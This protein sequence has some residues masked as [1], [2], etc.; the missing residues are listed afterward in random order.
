MQGNV[1]TTWVRGSVYA[2]LMGLALAWSAACSP[3]DFEEPWEVQKLRVLAVVAEPPELGPGE[4]TEIRAFSASPREDATFSWRWEVCLLTGGP[5]TS[6]AC[7]PTGDA[8][9]DGW[10]ASLGEGA[11]GDLFTLENPLPAEVLD[12]FCDELRA[13]RAELCTLGLP[14]TLRA[15]VT[16]EATGET[17]ITT[18]RMVLLRSDVAEREDRNVNPSLRELTFGEIDLEHNVVVE[19]PLPERGEWIDLEL[20]I[21][22]D[23]AQMYADPDSGEERMEELRVSWFVSGG[24]LERGQTF[25]RASV[26]DG[27]AELKA[28]RWRSHGDRLM[29]EGERLRIWAVIRD[30]RGGVAILERSLRWVAP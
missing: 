29:T 2:L 6:F 28:N 15:T 3:I 12:A 5:E 30:N 4:T 22:D 10:L 23:A 19:V 16:E 17:L 7:E 25:F 27:F 13:Q 20:E 26:T 14:V 24:E 9:L 8:E 21:P 11:E 1:C 18:R